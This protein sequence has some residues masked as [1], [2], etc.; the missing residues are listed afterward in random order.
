MAVVLLPGLLATEAGG[1]QQFDVDA[2]TVGDALRS[3]PVADLV[4]D[5]AGEV[6]SLVHVYVDGE[7][8]RDLAVALA[9]E[10]RIRIVAAIAGG[11]L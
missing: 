4:L 3:L 1:Q 5:E 2:A 7:R 6:R 11:A 9:P 8:I 10:A